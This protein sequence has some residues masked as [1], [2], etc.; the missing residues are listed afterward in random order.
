MKQ[1]KL[2]IIVCFALGIALLLGGT[3]VLTLSP[4]E[5]PEEP[6]TEESTTTEPEQ[7]TAPEPETEPPIDPAVQN[8]SLL[9]AK[10]FANP[11]L[12][13]RALKIEHNFLSLPGS[14]AAE[15]AAS[16]VEYGFGGAACNM[17]WDENYLQQGYTL[18]QFAAFVQAAGEQG[19]RIWL[20]D[21]YG[22][23]SG[24]AGDL[25]VKDHPEY[26]AVRLMQFTMSGGDSDT[27]RI[28]LPDDFVKIEYAYLIADGETVPIEVSVEDGKMCFNG[29]DKTWTAYVYCVTKY[30]Y[31]Y[32]WNSS[33]PNIINRDAVAR[34]I[35]VTF[36]TYEG[37]IENFGQVIEAIFDDEAQLLANHHLMPSDL[38]NP[39]IPY[40]YDIFDTFKIKYGYDVRPMLHLIYSGD[41]AQAQRVRAQFYAHVGDLVSENFFGQIQEWCEAHGTQLS[42]HLLLEEQ[43]QYHVP[44][45]GNYIQASKNMGY[46]GFD[47]L[48]VR[49]EPYLDS[50]STGAKYASSAAWLTGQERVMI[51]IAPANSPDEFA[52]NHLDYALGAMTFAYFDGGN[53][54]TSYY[55]QAGGDKATGQAFN[56][57]VGRMGAMT[58]GA[59][60]LSEIAIY[61]SID[62]M[63]AAYETP[64]SQNLY[65]APKQARELDTLVS[66]L[67]TGI[68]KKGL[69]Y[70]F[71]DDA[72][73]QQG[74]VSTKGLSVGNFTFTTVLVP[75][76]TVMD[77]ESMRVLDALIEAGVNVI[78]VEEMPSLA[79]LEKDQAEMEALSA[80]HASLLCT[81]YSDAISAI[82]VE[83]ELGVKSLRKYVYI[84]PYEKNGVKFFFLAL[85]GRKDAEI[86]LSYE[87]AIGFRIYDP[88]TGEIYEV[89]NTTTIKSY[90]AL[91]VQPLFAEE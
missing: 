57:Y 7:T 13:Y 46:A 91:F 44:V 71:I 37:A 59:Q 1:N 21:E 31:G 83:S 20:Y 54:I 6:G 36:E 65:D 56:E 76:A 60:N 90:R 78:F 23:P 62:A 69:D 30:N 2:I 85:D 28:A 53:Q 12:K 38:K 9:S 74:T 73:L 33:Y 82:K 42:G 80:K 24:A 39:V 51:E 35:E 18:E 3:L 17:K 32:E 55:S 66:R 86:T 11:A 72:S 45:Y 50:M 84:S 16:L 49:P 77:I 25:T 61:Y 27:R 88:L 5:Y 87:G 75:C 58:V 26:Q 19:V 70:V 34:F 81:K 79:F 89:E 48:N 68:R 41:S 67:T 15:K 64:D 52:T 63:A 29:V 10:D 22:Y 8:L 4:K 14:T 47:V 43:M 40:D